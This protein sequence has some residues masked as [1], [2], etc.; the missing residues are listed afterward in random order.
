MTSSSA[1]IIDG[2]ETGDARKRRMK[3]ERREYRGKRDF[4]DIELNRSFM[5]NSL[6]LANIIKNI[7]FS[8]IIKI[9]GGTG[10]T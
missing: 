7:R 6:G 4:L 9:T 8:L 10:I 1:F 5:D 3:A 2:D